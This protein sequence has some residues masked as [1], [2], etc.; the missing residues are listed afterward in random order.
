M[1]NINALQNPKNKMLQSY[2]KLSKK[3]NLNLSHLSPPP[4]PKTPSNSNLGGGNGAPTAYPILIRFFCIDIVRAYG[5]V[6]VACTEVEAQA[7]GDL[8]CVEGLAAALESASVSETTRVSAL[9]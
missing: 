1:T 6:G 7:Y 2:I 8:S 5:A 9:I 4:N 3:K